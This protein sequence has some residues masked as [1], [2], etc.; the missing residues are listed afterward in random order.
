MVD[1][2]QTTRQERIAE[3][4]SEIDIN[5]LD[6]HAKTCW[7]CLEPVNPADQGKTITEEHSP[8]RLKCGHTFG[9]LCISHW[10]ETHETCPE[11]RTEVVTVPV[12]LDQWRTQRA[13]I[14]EDLNAR[15]QDESRS[16]WLGAFRLHELSLRTTSKVSTLQSSSFLAPS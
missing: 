2:Y 12:G 4:L 10:L 14:L 16:D 7:I 13:A 9:K 6:Q 11:C 15:I 8:T 5:E 1:S 3:C